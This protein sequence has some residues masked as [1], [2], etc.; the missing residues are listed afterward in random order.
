MKNGILIMESRL[1][2]EKVRIESEVTPVGSMM[3]F[4]EAM[5]QERCSGIHILQDQDNQ[6]VVE[7]TDLFAGI[8]RELEAMSKRIS[9]NSL[10]ILAVNASN[11]AIQKILAGVTLRSDGVNKAMAAITTLMKNIP[12]KRELHLRRSLSS[13][14]RNQY[15]GDSRDGRL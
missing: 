8:R 2:T 4:Q 11:Q 14:H 7:V 6:M 5:L 13:G 9:D 3:Q 1:Q 15:Q 12:T 10:Q